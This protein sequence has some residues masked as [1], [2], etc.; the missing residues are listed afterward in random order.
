MSRPSIE[1]AVA[2]RMKK[3]KHVDQKQKTRKN[4]P[5]IV[6]ARSASRVRP[7]N[8]DQVRTL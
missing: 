7:R 8:G 5:E 3:V 6:D 4:W 2:T 1:T